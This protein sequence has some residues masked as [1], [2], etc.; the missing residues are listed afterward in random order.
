MT[1]FGVP[2]K[3]NRIEARRGVDI[4][5]AGIAGATSTPSRFVFFHD[6]VTARD[7]DGIALPQGQIGSLK[8]FG[9]KGVKLKR[10]S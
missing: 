8:F 6:D 10:R 3:G 9:D 7:L 5:D 1:R 4:L 2:S